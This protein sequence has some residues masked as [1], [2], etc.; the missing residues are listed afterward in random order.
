MKADN[1]ES[2]PVQNNFVPDDQDYDPDANKK[3]LN[4]SSNAKKNIN[5]SIHNRSTSKVHSLDEPEY[6]L[7]NKGTQS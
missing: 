5:K 4:I 3:P 6:S 7:T 1:K 2:Q